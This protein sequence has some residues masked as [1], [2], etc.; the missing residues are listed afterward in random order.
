[1]RAHARS[2]DVGRPM[3]IT[4]LLLAGTIWERRVMAF[5]PLI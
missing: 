5:R 2:T 4:T 1:M 3:A